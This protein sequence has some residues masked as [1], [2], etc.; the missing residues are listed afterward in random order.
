MIST[1]M[2]AMTLPTDPSP[3]TIKPLQTPPFSLAPPPPPLPEPAPAP[4]R[5]GLYCNRTKNMRILKNRR[6]WCGKTTDKE[7]FGSAGCGRKKMVIN[8]CLYKLWALIYFILNLAKHTFM[9]FNAFKV[10]WF[11]I[12]IRFYVSAGMMEIGSSMTR[13]GVDQGGEGKQG[14]NDY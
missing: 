5:G 4:P 14:V 9:L 12:K 6:T 7:S 3:S 11:R 13:Q 2:L 8:I 10:H 1:T